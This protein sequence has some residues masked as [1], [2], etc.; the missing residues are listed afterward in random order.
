[1]ALLILSLTMLV[2]ELIATIA[3]IA[4]GGGVSTT[5]EIRTPRDDVQP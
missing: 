3:M 2:K 4:Q 5:A 1:L